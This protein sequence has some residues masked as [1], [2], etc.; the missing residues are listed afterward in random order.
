MDTDGASDF[1]KGTSH[2]AALQTMNNIDNYNNTSRSYGPAE[3]LR[4]QQRRMRQAAS[5]ETQSVEILETDDDS[6]CVDYDTT[7]AAQLAMSA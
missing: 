4:R 6:L 2:A 3:Q 1:K 7:G 5:T